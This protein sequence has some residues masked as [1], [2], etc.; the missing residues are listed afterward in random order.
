MT[1][2]QYYNSSD[3]I[4]LR[5]AFITGN[6]NI[7]GNINLDNDLNIK[8]NLTVNEITANIV[9]TKILRYEELD[10]QIVPAQT[11]SQQGAPNNSF[12]TSPDWYIDTSTNK[13]YKKLL[14]PDLLSFPVFTGTIRTATDEASLTTAINASASGDIVEI[15]NNINL[16]TNKTSN[17]K[18]ILIRSQLSS[19]NKYTIN[20]SSTTSVFST[21][22]SICFS[23]LNIVQAVASTGAQAILTL[24]VAGS[25][26]TSYLPIFIDNCTLGVSEFGLSGT[27]V[28]DIQIT[29]SQFL[30]TGLSTANNHAF[31]FLT[32]M[33]N[34]YIDNCEFQNSNDLAT[35]RSRWIQITPSGPSSGFLNI[36]G[37]LRLSN[38]RDITNNTLGRG[39]QLFIYEGIILGSGISNT[40]I[41]MF[42]NTFKQFTGG[43]GILFGNQLLNSMKDIVIYNNIYSNSTQQKGLI[44]LD[45]ASGSS[46]TGLLQGQL[47]TDNT[48]I[49]GDI[50]AYY[51]T[52][53]SLI[54]LDTTLTQEAFQ[55]TYNTAIFSVASAMVPKNLENGQQWVYKMVPLGREILQSGSASGVSI[56]LIISNLNN[57]NYNF[58]ELTLYY[59]PSTLSSISWDFSIN[60]GSSYSTTGE[61]TSSTL[62]INADNWQLWVRGTTFPFALNGLLNSNAGCQIKFNWARTVFSSLDFVSLNFET[63]QHTSGVGL[64]L[65]KGTIT[66]GSNSMPTNFRFTNT[67]GSGTVS[68]QYQLIGYN[69]PQ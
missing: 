5:D 49:A 4:Y 21:N 27:G 36:R 51:S 29:N 17:D 31:L 58:F 68:Y 56:P 20:S 66:T 18:S 41:Y 50:S 23:K 54:T 9:D 43:F 30:Y 55:I 19:G 40:S 24:S 15:L 2:P 16:T 14:V 63:N 64:Q 47:Y 10:P 62:R 7:N 60:N 37:N 35:G 61:I 28:N 52:Y 53:E 13:N 67:S 44:A 65:V 32:G 59:A 6:V 25:N 12:G 3:N 45:N 33:K 11:Y 38:S 39:R 8:G 1:T 46:N 42:N 26:P 57:T 48:N 22:G 69:L 34:V